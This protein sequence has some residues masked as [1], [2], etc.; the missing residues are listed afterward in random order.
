MLLNAEEDMSDEEMLN[1][2]DTEIA[3]LELRIK[4]YEDRHA[5]EM[6]F[7]HYIIRDNP[8]NL[9]KNISLFAMEQPDVSVEYADMGIFRGAKNVEMF[10]RKQS[11][12]PV[13]EGIYRIRWLATPMIEIAK[14]GKTARGAWIAPGAEAFVE[15]NGSGKGHALWNF[16]RFA[17]DF[18]KEEQG[19]KIWHLRMFQEV[20]CDFDKGW[21]KDFCQY[22]YFGKQ[23]NCESGDST[24]DNP[25]SPTFIQEVIPKCPKPYETWNDEMWYLN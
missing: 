5:I 4:R 6:L 8:R 20:R 14:D 1:E 7:G 12:L 21:G 3:E 11:S 23:E 16:V 15:A 19:W 17:V 13:Y 9:K 22:V 25:Y 2:L 18:I 10:I 24:Y